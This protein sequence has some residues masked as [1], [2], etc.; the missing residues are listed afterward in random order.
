MENQENVCEEISTAG[1]EKEEKSPLGKFKDVNALMQAYN[2]LQAEFTR[3]SQRLKQLER[4]GKSME[5][6]A[7][8]SCEEKTQ[9]EGWQGC[10]QASEPAVGE[11]KSDPLT[12]MVAE[13]RGEDGGSVFASSGENQKDG[14]EKTYPSAE[15]VYQMAS[16]DEKVRLQ[17][18]GDYLQSLQKRGAPISMGGMGALV[19]PPK[20]AQSIQAAGDMALRLFKDSNKNF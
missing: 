9:E 15:E 11:L 7:M 8:P 12:R 4:S 1:Q 20:K 6:E 16:K 18:V 13:A 5:E 19:T 17:I 14:D 3:R 2:S 10:N